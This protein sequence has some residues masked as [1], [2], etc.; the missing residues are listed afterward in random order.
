MFGPKVWGNVCYLLWQ[1]VY[2][3]MSGL[4]WFGLVWYCQEGMWHWPISTGPLPLGLPRCGEPHTCRCA[5]PLTGRFYW[6]PSPP[7]LEDRSQWPGSNFLLLSTRS[8]GFFYVHWGQNPTHT[9]PFYQF[10]AL[11]AMRNSL[12]KAVRYDGS[13]G[14]RTPDLSVGSPAP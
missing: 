4:V 13:V 6:V 1:Y 11:E 10:G 2:A 8:D 9:R 5:L 14:I 7:Y 3:R 12:P